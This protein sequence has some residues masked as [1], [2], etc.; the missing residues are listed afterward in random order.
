MNHVADGV[1]VGLHQLGDHRD[2]DSTSRPWPAPQQDVE[3]AIDILDTCIREAHGSRP[4]P[5]TP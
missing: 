4:E 3:Q 1:L 2:A 5:A